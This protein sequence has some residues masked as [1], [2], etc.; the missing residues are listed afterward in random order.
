[1][2]DWAVEHFKVMEAKLWLR[3]WTGSLDEPKLDYWYI[4]CLDG[5]IGCNPIAFK[6]QYEMAPAPK[7]DLIGA[8]MFDSMMEP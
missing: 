1:V 5:L 8:T 6:S 2:P 3:N 4:E 7:V